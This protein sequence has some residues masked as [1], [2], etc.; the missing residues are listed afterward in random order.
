MGA[1]RIAIVDDHP[2]ICDGIAT[3][4]HSWPNGQVVLKAMNGEEYANAVQDIGHVDIA[5]ID[6]CMPV[7]DG[8][9]T[10][11]WMRTNQQRTLPVMLTFDPTPEV[12]SK[13]VRLGARGV[14]GKN[15]HREEL[16]TALD[17]VSATGYYMN[18]HMTMHLVG[19]QPSADPEPEP[20]GR[21][22]VLS[23]LTKRELEVIEQICA[24]DDPTYP[25]VAERMGLS[26]NTVHTYRARIF[27]KLGV[28]NRQGLLRAALN[29]KLLKRYRH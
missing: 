4:L 28:S 13:V 16:H 2:M 22:K 15:I 14:L 9:S 11:E 29:W 26:K 19:A 21:A 17:H 3:M 10:L 20:Q 18:E 5:L 8:F 6:V 25:M 23:C 24:H 12:V 7:R 27:G 1:L